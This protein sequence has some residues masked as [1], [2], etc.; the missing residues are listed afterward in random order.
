VPLALNP[1]SDLSLQGKRILWH[2]SAHGWGHAARQ[3][4]LIRTVKERYPGVSISLVS[5]APDWFW[6]G[7]AVGRIVQG[8]LSPITLEKNGVPDRELTAA[9]L[10]KFLSMEKDLLSEQLHLQS[11]TAADLVITDIDPLPVKAADI[12]SIPAIGIGNFTWD[13]ILSEMCP[14]L[15][16]E[17]DRIA[18]MYST[19]IYL[20][21]PMGPDHSPFKTSF[22]M[23]LLRG[24]PRGRPEQVKNLLPQE[25]VRC[26][27]AFRHL[28]ESFPAEFPEGMTVITSMPQPQKPGWLN[29]PQKTLSVHEASFAD[30]VAAA[31][32]V[33]TKPGY[34]IVS[35][36]LSMGK[37]AVLVP[38]GMFPE[39]KHL[40]SALKHRESTEITDISCCSHLF[41]KAMKVTRSGVP[42][43]ESSEGAH[44][45]TSFIGSNLNRYRLPFWLSST[46]TLS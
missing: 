10:S 3:R 18:E 22:E 38:G 8:N 28:P 15:K 30:L 5:S 20:R 11:A 44:L 4:E 37:P 2:V 21:L 14:D 45:I 25:G 23:P 16:E 31:D 29:I 7:A 40:L 43:A 26:L 19:G 27:V 32:V 34:G 17:T 9:N 42:K 24:G 33:I 12:N 46:Y 13:W 39:E 36:I 41:Q 1:Q 6:E 35:Q